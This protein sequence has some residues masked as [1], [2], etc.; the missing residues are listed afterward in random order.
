MS[1]LG[2]TLAE[3][4]ITLGIIGIVAALTMPSL[5]ANHRKLVVENKLK[6]F[7][8]S[9]S[10]AVISAQSST[11]VSPNEWD[12]FSS[13]YN[14]QEMEAW[15]NKYLKNYLQVRDVRQDKG[16]G[17][18]YVALS[19]GT[20][21]IIF[22]HSIAISGIHVYYCTNYNKC[23]FK[24]DGKEIFTFMFSQKGFVTYGQDNNLTK[25]QLLNPSLDCSCSS[26]QD[27]PHYCS[28]LIQREGW[29]IPDDYPFR[30]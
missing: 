8:S 1:R 12:R 18:L 16:R 3:V 27:Y 13:T 19:D 11:G 25:R 20:G 14:S 2:F 17:C 22:N 10:Q 23:K 26:A 21:F 7:Y 29:K 4:L 28:T 15:F 6:K 24:P 30:I 5:I 9:M